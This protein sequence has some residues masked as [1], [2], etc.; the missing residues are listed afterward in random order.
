MKNAAEARETV[1]RGNR[2]K[3]YDTVCGWI[4]LSPALIGFLA[5]TIVPVLLSLYY[6]FTE[7]NLL[8]APVWKGIDNYINMFRLADFKTAVKNTLL[9]A[10]VVVV[11]NLVL[12][13][14]IAYLL[15]S[16]L[17]GISVFRTLFY[18]P[19]IIPGV[20]GAFTYGNLFDASTGYINQILQAIGL[21]AQ[22][23]L[24]D[25]KTAVPTIIAM[26]LWGMGGPML[27][28]LAAFK[29]VPQSLYEAARIDGSKWYQ[30]LV[31]ITI[32]LCTPMIFYNAVTGV[33]NGLQ[34]FG[35][36]YLLTNG[37]PQGSTVTLVMLIY[38][39]GIGYYQMGLASAI[40]WFL[41]AITMIMTL[42]LFATKKW[43][44]TE[45]G[46]R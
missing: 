1:K 9:F 45:D 42:I 40:A 8:S 23:F 46:A 31:H 2:K 28:W 14:S 18:L 43:V 6:S 19:C 32:P 3:T 12:S 13:F 39:R 11:M 38:N 35:S 10:T 41:F 5:F 22:P 44:Y 17:K 16:R 4:F 33:I 34:T 27:I 26:G 20:A 30:D 36:V 7:Y 21:P 37:G 24:T 15:N 29:S 25:P